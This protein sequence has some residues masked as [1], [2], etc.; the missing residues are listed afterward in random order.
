MA[1]LLRQ[2][3]RLSQAVVVAAVG[4][5][6][7]NLGLAV[8]SVALA[9]GVWMFITDTE[10]PTRT[11]VFPVDIPVEPVTMP[12]GLTL[13]GPL[14]DVTLRMEADEDLW[15]ELT[16]SDFE[17]TVNLLGAQIGTQ[18]VEV[19]VKPLGERNGLRIIEVIPTLHAVGAPAGTV[20]VE[21]KPLVSQVVHV[22]VDVVGTPP[23]GYEPSNPSVDP[24][25]VVVSGPEELVSRVAAAVAN[26][27]LSGAVADVRQTYSLVPRD[28]SGFIV[29]GVTLDP[30][31]VDI[32]I[33]VEQKRFSRLVVVSPSLEGSPAAG[34]NVTAVEVEPTSVTLLGPL[35]LLNVTSFVVTDDIDITGATSDTTR[36]VYLTGLP[37]GVSVSGA[38]TVSVRIRISAA[39]GEATFGAAPQW[40]GLASDLRVVSGASLVEVTLQGELPALRNVSPDEVTVSVDLSGLGAGSHRLEPKVEAPAGLEV[41]NISPTSVDVVLEPAP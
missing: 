28:D 16:A 26:V 20:R 35:E 7:H 6:R 3:L 19:Q 37:T 22:G 23:M 41:A 34:Y 29:A 18:D 4:S 31:T 30:N 10:H 36:I 1:R 38:G 8:L 9:F 13:G 27:D 32:E 14:G 2:F 17:A 12:E 24:D 40:T 25:Q 15:D 21:L 5:V 11:G 33:T 39:E